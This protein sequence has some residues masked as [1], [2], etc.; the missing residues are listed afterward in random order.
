MLN[1]FPRKRHA[2]HST[3]FWE[4]LIEMKR[5]RTPSNILIPQ[6]VL[7]SISVRST[8]RL[9]TRLPWEWNRK[10]QRKPSHGYQLR[11]FEL[12]MLECCVPPTSSYKWN[13]VINGNWG[14]TPYKW[15]D[16]SNLCRRCREGISWFVHFLLV[17][18]FTSA[19]YSCLDSLHW[20]DDAKKKK[21]NCGQLVAARQVLDYQWLPARRNLNMNFHLKTYLSLV[22]R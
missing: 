20:L 18:C 22:Y 7:S 13:K 10:S 16:M 5:L 3:D 19:F 15:T 1:V 14:V 17:R 6:R 8:G 2:K 9:S 4:R 12:F 11:M 21:I